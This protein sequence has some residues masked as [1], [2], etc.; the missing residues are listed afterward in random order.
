MEQLLHDQGGATGETLQTRCPCPAYISMAHELVPRQRDTEV[1]YGKSQVDTRQLLLPLQWG[2]AEPSTVESL[3][4]SDRNVAI[5]LV[6]AL[7]EVLNGRRPLAQVEPVLD[8]H[9]YRSVVTRVQNSIL[10][11][12]WLQLRSFS[13]QLPVS[14]I[15]EGCGTIDIGERSRAFVTRFERH[16]CTWKCTRFAILWPSTT[17]TF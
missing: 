2:S 6:V 7:V 5:R 13:A 16:D 17:G 1:S 11:R 10:R 15:I 3:S 8:S 12:Q 9:I 4:N 14:G